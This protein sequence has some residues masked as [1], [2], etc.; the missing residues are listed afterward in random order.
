MALYGNQWFA[1]SGPSDDSWAG[2]TES[3]ADANTFVLEM[4]GT[5]TTEIGAGFGI[6]Q[7]SAKQFT[8]SGT[9]SAVDSDGYRT[10]NDGK[11]DFN[12]SP[13]EI[14]AGAFGGGT[15]TWFWGMKMKDVVSNSDNA[16]FNFIGG[17]SGAT[18]DCSIYC[19]KTN[20][21]TLRF[22]AT[23]NNGNGA[24]PHSPQTITFQP[25]S[26]YYVW[27]CHWSDG[28]YVRGGWVQSATD[29]TGPKN[30]SDFPSTQRFSNTTGQGFDQG[31]TAYTFHVQGGT[32]A[33][34][35]Q[36][37][38]NAQGEYKLNKFVISTNATIVN[39]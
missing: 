15:N 35:G 28:T 11:F 29:D 3:D 21:T 22:L 24:Q 33:G 34:I 31:G 12:T 19:A 20:S 6:T 38:A 2:L 1:A 4:E 18:A 8:V 32:G 25:N 7:N 14:L 26:T 5:G 23:T 16:F 30:Y 27:L 37:N 13:S 9:V 36:N 17:T 10:L 39:D